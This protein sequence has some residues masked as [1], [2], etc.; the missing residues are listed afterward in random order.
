MTRGR[1]RIT[2]PPYMG[3]V[4]NSVIHTLSDECIGPELGAVDLSLS[5]IVYTANLVVYIPLI[6]STPYLVKQ[7]FWQN[8]SVAADFTD[9]G[10]YSED[11]QTKYGST[12]ATANTPINTLQAVNVTDFILPANKRFWMALGSDSA[13]QAYR[14]LDLVFEG[15]DFIGVKQQASGYSSG[16]PATATLGTPTVGVTPLFGFIGQAVI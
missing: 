13:T 9:V 4:N 3:I 2:I 8:A 5:A 11:G 1:S 15:L 14:S 16:L 7:M 12:G 10:I 6:L